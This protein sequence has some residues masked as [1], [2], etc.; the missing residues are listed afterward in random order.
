MKLSL[1]L[2]MVSPAH[3]Y[4]RTWEGVYITGTHPP[5]A[6]THTHT[7]YVVFVTVYT[8]H[9]LTVR[10]QDISLETCNL[11]SVC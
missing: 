4:T 9:T 10:N 8:I 3:M 6:C 5:Q 1:Y 2:S 7:L 11:D